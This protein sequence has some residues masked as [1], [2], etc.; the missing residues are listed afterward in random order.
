MIIHFNIHFIT[1]N[2]EKIYL[3]VQLGNQDSVTTIEMSCDEN[4]I[5]KVEVELTERRK[6]LLYKYV[7]V[8]ADGQ[9]IPEPFIFRRLGTRMGESVIH[10]KDSWRAT[11]GNSPF[12][13]SAFQKCYF[14][15]IPLYEN[16]YNQEDILLQLFAPNVRAD[17]HIAIIGNQEILGNWEVNHKVKLNESRYPVWSISINS[18]DISFPLEYKYVI[19]DT[20][21]GEIIDWEVGPNRH[22]DNL[23]QFTLNVIT[24]ENFIRS[25][26]SW[27]GAGVAIPIFSL[28][29]KHSFGVGDFFDMKLM[30][31]WAKL[32]GQKIV[33]TLP[34]ND[35][36]RYHNNN[37]SYPYNA[38]SV[39]ALHP[40]YIH[41]DEIGEIKDFERKAYFASKRKAL[42]DKSFVDYENVMRVKWEYCKE[43]YAEDSSQVFQSYDYNLFY[44]KNSHWLVPYAVFSHLRN[45]YGTPDFTKWEILSNYNQE[46]VNMFASPE[47]TYYN[48]IALH[49]FVQYH[50]DKQLSDVHNY[51]ASQGVTIKGDIPIGVNPQSVDTWMEPRLFNRFV[52]AGAPPDDFSTTGQNWG[53]PTYNWKLMEQDNY[54]WWRNR[55]L[56]LAEYFDAYRIDHILG[57]FRIWEIPQEDVWGLTG[58]FQPSLPFTIAE[59]ESR[60]LKWELDRFTKLY[61]KE[62]VIKATFGDETDEILSLYFE[63]DGWQTYKFKTEY[64][65]QKKIYNH[66]QT[67]NRPLTD[68]EI[69]I[70][71]RL[72]SLHTEVLFIRD[73]HQPDK[74]H[75]RITM[76]ST[77]SFK[78]LPDDIAQLLDSI[79]IDYFYYRHN[80]FW[81]EQAMEK[82]PVLINS[83]NM[84]VCGED[85][86][87]VPESVPEVM[88]ALEI[89]SLEI[90]RM[91]KEAYHEFG[92]PADAPYLSVCTTSTHD[93]N[94]I[95]AW[96]LEDRDVSQ[97]F[98]NTVLGLEGAAPE[99][100]EPWI[101]EKIVRQHLESNA[102]FAILPWQDW[103]AIDGENA[104][105]VPISERINV[106]GDPYN[107]WCYRMHIPLE[108][109]MK[110]DIL[111]TKIKTMIE[112]SGR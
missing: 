68:P 16:L 24:D 66:Y 6:E 77:F 50:L 65:S 112:E 3:H 72:Y 45:M 10:V 98:Y 75:P 109:L 95:R 36:T 100:C 20:T 42:N 25:I 103:L 85:L 96:W 12:M 51:A 62:H 88:A 4:S 18:S 64:D 99:Q 15:R 32:T 43:V 34:I 59:L 47:H 63:D 71:D 39:Y 38:I 31:D 21:T 60:G 28:R 102:M 29:S 19:V 11:F 78:D 74:F 61:L 9:Q 101:A 90:Q 69:I 67:L 56:K 37:D 81:K 33:Q 97:R 54:E 94:P 76:H 106:P 41:L 1:Y 27:K 80:A 83:T 87:M 92:I 7:L 58:S 52:Q 104:S 22:V 110:L 5:W 48:D 2:D 70:R 26:P 107:F 108:K 49:Y 8:K 105:K 82:L 44:K 57:F 89:L 46:E 30:V 35:T 73:V 84:L 14:K 53:F 55:F 40:I 111:N 23:A 93:T 17:R 86:G 79:Y 91:P 13:S